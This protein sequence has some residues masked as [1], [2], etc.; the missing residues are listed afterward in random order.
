MIPVRSRLHLYL[1]DEALLWIPVPDHRSAGGH[2]YRAM[3]LSPIGHRIWLHINDSRDI[4]LIAKRTGFSVLQVQ[5]FCAEMCTPEVQVLQ[6]RGKPA[7]P[8]DLS[9]QRLIG[10]SRPDNERPDHLTGND[11]QTDLVHYHLHEIHDGHTHFDNRE[12][13]V[14]H[15]FGRPHPALDGL[16]F[17][18]RLYDRVQATFNLK[19]D[20]QIVEVGCGTGEMAGAWLKRANDG[21]GSRYVRVDLSPELLRTQATNAGDSLS[22]LADGTALPLPNESVDLLLSNEVIADMSAVPV[23]PDNPTPS[24]AEVLQRIQRYDLPAPKTPALYNLGAW[25]FLEEIARVLSPGGMAWVSEF[26]SL[27][28]APEEAR[29]LD[30]PEVSIQFGHLCTIAQALG[31]EVECVP[32][33]EWMQFSMHT[34]QPARHS[35]MAMRALAKSQNIHLSARAWQPIDLMPGKLFPF[36][37]AGIHWVSLH[38]PGPGP[39]IARFWILLL[40]KKRQLTSS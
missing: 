8:N 23:D 37:V 10:I 16:T 11:G 35:W 29:Q 25:L 34:R 14:A 33:A 38:S 5:A 30:H 22:I 9:L 13:T 19:T 20:S 26:G 39:L 1:P 36:P 7:K 24:A 18:A 12:T 17:G 28:E 4:L 31:L 6:L 3:R 27:E 2:G 21:P 15:C 32:M 40:R